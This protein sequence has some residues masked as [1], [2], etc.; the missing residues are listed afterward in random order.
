LSIHT[1]NPAPAPASAAALLGAVVHG[2]E[3]ALEALDVHVPI[4]L[5]VAALEEAA[6]LR[7]GEPILVAHRLIERDPL[8]TPELVGRHLAEQVQHVPFLTA[9][10]PAPL[11]DSVQNLLLCEQSLHLVVVQ[12]RDTPLRAADRITPAVP[13][14]ELR[15]DRAHAPLVLHSLGPEQQLVVVEERTAVRAR[16]LAGVVVPPG[17][18]G[19]GGERGGGGGGG[20]GSRG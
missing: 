5:R 18:G 2:E 16:V 4:P 6:R 11:V 15:D 12:R 14:L 3:R 1:L 19:G 20:G 17:G 8:H 9:Q 13:L 10:V 7:L